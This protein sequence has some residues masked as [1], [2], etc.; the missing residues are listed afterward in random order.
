MSTRHA[1]GTKRM[2][3]VAPMRRVLL[4][5]GAIVGL[6]WVVAW[7]LGGTADAGFA[8]TPI[9]SPSP[10]RTLSDVVAALERAGLAVEPTSQ[11]LEQP[12]FAVPA[13]IVRVEGQDLQVFV[14]ASTAAR[15]ADSDQISADGTTVG[16]SMVMW[17]A[18]PHFTAA[19]NVLTLFVSN[20]EALAKRIA[21]AVA[22]LAGPGRASPVA[23]PAV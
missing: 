22:D 8:A 19:E 20:D 13:T 16:T 9:A 10:T 12:F 5:L 17:V 3:P 23:S 2:R 21:D 15:T 18:K 11:T 6:T 7:S 4:T 1:D 14:Y